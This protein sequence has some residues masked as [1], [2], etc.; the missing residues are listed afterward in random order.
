MPAV[1]FV[2]RTARPDLWRALPAGDVARTHISHLALSSMLLLTAG[3]RLLQERQRPQ[4]GIITA[5]VGAEARAGDPW[6]QLGHCPYSR[7]Q[8]HRA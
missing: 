7:F 2:A 6:S 8:S 3:G 4:H 5:E 1:Q